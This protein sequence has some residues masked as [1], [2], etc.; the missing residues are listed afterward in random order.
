ML[1]V[2]LSS[3]WPRI[4]ASGFPDP[5]GPEIRKNVF[6]STSSIQKIQSKKK[7]VQLSLIIKVSFQKNFLQQIVLKEELKTSSN[8]T[9]LNI[10][11]CR[12]E[13]AAPKLFGWRRSLKGKQKRG[14][15]ILLDKSLVH[16]NISYVSKESMVNLAGVGHEVPAP[17]SFE[18]TQSNSSQK[19][20]TVGD[21]M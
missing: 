20:L 17:A 10:W 14:R 13:M 8:Q 9:L 18:K 2:P 16:N 11:C 4:E 5:V 19:T 12:K 3:S 1:E 21:P 15:R 6:E 7:V